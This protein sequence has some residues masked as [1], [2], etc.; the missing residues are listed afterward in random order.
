MNGGSVS[1]GQF[2]TVGHSNLGLDDFIFMLQSH[3]INLLVDVR[4][5]PGSRKFPWF[6][7]ETLIDS[8]RS[9]NIEYQHIRDLGG[10]RR[11]SKAET[12]IQLEIGLETGKDGVNGGWDTPNFRNYADYSVSDPRFLGGIDV[13]LSLE[14]RYDL[15][16]MCSEAVPWRCHRLLVTNHLLANGH[17]V[18]HIMSANK[19]LPAEFGQFGAEPQIMYPRKVANHN[20]VNTVIYPKVGE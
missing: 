9:S 13:L 6:N 16:F 2:H 4:S 3:G 8:A 5:L 1:F 14:K 15:A 10:Y 7:K 12:P 18:N 17:V 20:P 11:E 19:L